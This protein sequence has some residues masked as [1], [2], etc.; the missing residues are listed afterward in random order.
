MC[1]AS[2]A[3]PG[4]GGEQWWQPGQLQRDDDGERHGGAAG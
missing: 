4:M 3:S 1:F 2:A